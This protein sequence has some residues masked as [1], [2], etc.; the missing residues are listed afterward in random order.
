MFAADVRNE[1]AAAFF[2]AT[3][4]NVHQDA[5]IDF[6][7]AV[8]V[9]DQN[10]NIATT[11]LRHSAAPAFAV[12]R[13]VRVDTVRLPTHTASD[14]FLNQ[15]TRAC[16]AHAC[17]DGMTQAPFDDRPSVTQLIAD[18]D[19]HVPTA[20]NRLFDLLYKDLHRV[21]RGRVRMNGHSLDLS[22]T[23][24]LHETYERLVQLDE[25]KV[26]DRK[27][28]FTYAAAVMR[29]VVVD[30]ARA[31]LTDRR[32]GGLSDIPFDTILEGSIATPLDES[33]LEISQA[34]DQLAA[35]EPRLA[36]VVEMRYF[37]GM[38]VDETAL[39]LGVTERTVGRDW[40]KARSLLAAILAA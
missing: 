28:F 14:C 27:Q 33:V 9:Q 40:I 20:V 11:S 35:V 19:A 38:T 25:L 24:L 26:S 31:R 30:M 39:A 2:P 4:N 13:T 6:A 32:G 22:A 12:V 17:K 5:E 21:A 23:S 8:A 7:S 10:M 16:I 29:S 3:R 1:T 18:A 34:L 37:A 15:W 36:R